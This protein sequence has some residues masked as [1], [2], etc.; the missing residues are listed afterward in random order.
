MLVLK[1]ILQGPK[2]QLKLFL[3][4]VFQEPFGSWTSAPK[5]VDVR[6]QKCVFQRPDDGE[7][8]FDPGHP[9]MRV[10]NV[11]AKSGPKTVCL[12]CFSS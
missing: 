2:D 10:R 9:R 12:C 3:Y 1:G 7:K 8:L 11:R 5:I 6:T 4:K